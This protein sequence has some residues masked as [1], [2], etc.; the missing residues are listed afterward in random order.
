MSGTEEQ[1]NKCLNVKENV[2]EKQ[3][4]DTYKGLNIR[5]RQGK[6]AEV[7]EISSPLFMTVDACKCSQTILTRIVNSFLKARQVYVA[8]ARLV[9]LANVISILS[10]SFW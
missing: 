1:F 3:E 7:Y 5:G 8:L 10:C 2:K 6:N 4:E 9:T